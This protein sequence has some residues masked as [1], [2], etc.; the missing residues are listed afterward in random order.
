MSFLDVDIISLN[1]LCFVHMR[2]EM[3]ILDIIGICLLEQD[4][5]ADV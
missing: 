3:E 2:H 4:V 1:C 5:C